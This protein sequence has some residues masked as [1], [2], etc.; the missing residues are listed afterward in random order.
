MRK[1][2]I[3]YKNLANKKTLQL[4]KEIGISYQYFEKIN[5]VINKLGRD[6]F[7]SQELSEIP[8]S[9]THLWRGSF[10][11]ISKRGTEAKSFLV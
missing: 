11:D 1:S 6:E 5:G 9:Y 8:V 10:L 3:K 2:Q 7:T 4:S